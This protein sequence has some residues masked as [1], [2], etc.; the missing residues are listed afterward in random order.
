MQNNVMGTS[1]KQR[2]TSVEKSRIATKLKPPHLTK[3]ISS[4]SYSVSILAYLLREENS[5]IRTA[6]TQYSIKA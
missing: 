5:D 1:K 3:H 6:V 4:Y 2:H